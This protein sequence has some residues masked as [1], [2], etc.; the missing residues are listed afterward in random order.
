MDNLNLQENKIKKINKIYENLTYF[1]QYGSSVIIFIIL[2]IILFMI[3]S[4]TVVMLQIQPI[5]DDWQNQRCNPK[6]IPFVS[7]IN[8]PNNK[9]A[10]EYTQENFIYC[11]QTILTKMSS[12]ALQPLTFLTAK[13]NLLFGNL[14]QDVQAGRNM[15]DNIRNNVNNIV[16]EIMGRILNFVV[17]LQQ[18]I[19]GMKD[20]IAKT[21]AILITGL[22]TSLG[23]YFTLKA[24]LGSIVQF[25]INILIALVVTILVM[26]IFP[27]TWGVAASMTAIF[28]AIS[29]P[30]A[31]IVIF[32]SSVLHIHSNSI[33]KVPSKPRLCFDENTLLRMKDG[34]TKPM[35]EINVGDKLEYDI[36][37]TTKIKVLNN[38]TMMYNLYGVTVSDSHVVYY[39]GSWIQV[40]N[41]P[42]AILI[43]DYDKP[44]LYCL[45]TSI[46]KIFINGVIFSDW[47]DLYE[48]DTHNTI[49]EFIKMEIIKDINYKI[50]D[51]DIHKYLD[52]GFSGETKLKLFNGDIKKIKDIKIGDIL[53]KGENVYGLVEINGSNTHNHVEYNLGNNLNGPIIGSYNIMFSIDDSG[54]CHT[55]NLDK[56]YKKMLLTNET[57]LYHLLTYSGIF[58]INNI[59]IYDY[60]APLD[61]ILENC[62]KIY[63]L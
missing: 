60:N 41:H 48:L 45:N 5:K 40:M 31:I 19:I 12:F 20:V 17:P 55:S 32:M 37:V 9:T 63:Y 62:N 11:T 33:P 39:N 22:F 8:K 57:K 14:S 59:T 2:T 16:Q 13:L 44:Y 38:S 18:L 35:Y 23:T 21:Q 53:E 43:E 52:Y 42:D 27:F 3:Y 25:I 56:T 7:L 15:F 54:I 26:W 29:I 36:E 46:K 49:N 50:K 28:I 1:D 47:D 58:H 61:L 24:L 4:Y 30:L 6:V 10:N 51:I 34:T